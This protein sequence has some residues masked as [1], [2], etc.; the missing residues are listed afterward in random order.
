VAHRGRRLGLVGGDE[1]GA[2]AE[3]GAVH[4]AYTV[5]FL[6][7]AKQHEVG[8][9][10]RFD[11]VEPAGHGGAGVDVGQADR[12]DVGGEDLAVRPG[13]VDGAV[14]VCRPG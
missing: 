10:V 14:L 4:D 3:G 2:V 9:G 13:Q 1:L 7:V 5:A 6:V 11:G 12:R 8:R